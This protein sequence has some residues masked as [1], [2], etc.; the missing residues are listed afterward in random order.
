[1]ATAANLPPAVAG[2]PAPETRKAGAS[3]R[4]DGRNQPGNREIRAKASIPLTLLMW[5]IA[6]I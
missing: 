3:H 2:E 1:M 5:V 6:A 4:K